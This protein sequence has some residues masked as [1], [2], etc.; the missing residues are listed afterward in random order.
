[1]YLSEIN[2]LAIIACG[3]ASLVI[4]GIWYGAIFKNAWIALVN[5]SEE[6]LKA[7]EKDAPKAYIGAF[8]G[9]MITAFVLSYVAVG[10]KVTNL[11]GILWMA[12][13]LWL[14]IAMVLRFNDVLFEKRPL[15]LFFI[16]TCFDLV[17]IL[18][19]SIIVVLWR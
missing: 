15:K 2:W 11:G 18:V 10:M 4:G 19:I 8:V 1:M 14:G 12:F 5:K 17:L 13:F 7:M 3:V 16:N 9:A 6:E